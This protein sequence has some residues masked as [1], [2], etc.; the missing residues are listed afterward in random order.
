MSERLCDVTV[1]SAGAFIGGA[2]RYMVALDSWLNGREDRPRI[3]GRGRRLTP[4]WLMQRE[5]EAR[6]ARMQVAL[7]NVSF[8][9]PRRSSC[10]RVVLLRNALHFTSDSELSALN[11]RLPRDLA[12]Q[13]PIVRLAATRADRVIVPSSSMAD[14]VL[15]SVP[16]LQSRLEVWPHP[17]EAR[18]WVGSK[19]DARNILVPIVNNPY[20]QL[21]KHLV[22]LKRA[23]DR[24]QFDGWVDIT[25]RAADFPMLA[26]DSRFKFR[27][28]MPAEELDRYWREAAVIYFP[29][30]LESFGY[31]LAE[32]RVNGRAVLA[33]D[34]LQAREIAGE[35]LCGFRA[36]SDRSLAEAVELAF[37]RIIAP[38][39]DAFSPASYFD[40][41]FG[42]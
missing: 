4:G 22:L 7:N 40:G 36:G 17:V 34:T 37:S 1:D 31:P 19:P 10:A 20:K 35:A 29:P 42:R 28:V 38:D 24:T 39:P 8:A 9:W 14:R 6:S 27:G 3:I 25:S 41:V 2:A 21:R 18:P 32:A 23:L 13:V 26:G 11:Y 5:W 15:S 16:G 30:E 33:P 12:A